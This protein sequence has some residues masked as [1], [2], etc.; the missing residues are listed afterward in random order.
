[1]ITRED[2]RWQVSAGDITN[3]NLGVCV[4][5]RHSYKDVPRHNLIMVS[6][7]K[8]AS[9][10]WRINWKKIWPGHALTDPGCC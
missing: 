9:Q 8:S 7:Q 10:G 4:R 6:N 3:M 5:P 1:M 2:I